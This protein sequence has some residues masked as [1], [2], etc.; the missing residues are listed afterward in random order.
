MKRKTLYL[1]ICFLLILNVFAFV[2]YLHEISQHDIRTAEDSEKGQTEKEE[3]SAEID[4][5]GSENSDDAGAPAGAYSSAELDREPL[6]A[7]VDYDTEDAEGIQEMLTMTGCTSERVG[8]IEDLDVDK[9]DAI[10]IPGGNSVDPSMYG[11]E[12]Q[13]ETTHTN[14]EKD[15]F[16]F[17]AVRMYADA[18]KPVL[19]ICRGEQLVN[20]VFGGTTIQ[21][22]PEGW[23][24]YERNVRIAEGTWLYDVLGSEESTYHFHHQCVDQLGEGLYATQWDEQDGHIEAYEHKTLPVYGLQWHPEGIEESGVSVFAAYVEAVK[25]NMKQH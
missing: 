25:E 22:M 17:A 15:E 18:G 6:I 14:K 11:A 9:Y 23:H 16:Q 10:I 19:G 4:E 3:A 8:K 24:K 12:R 2:L 7:V 5:K 1:I 13:P 20:N 21:H